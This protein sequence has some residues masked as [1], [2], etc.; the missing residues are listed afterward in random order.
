M[1]AIIGMVENWTKEQYQGSFEKRYRPPRKETDYSLNKSR[2]FVTNGGAGVG[3]GDSE[4]YVYNSNRLFSY[5]KDELLPFKPFRQNEKKILVTNV[6][7]YIHSLKGST[8][9]AAAAR[10]DND[11][12]D[13]DWE[14]VSQSLDNRTP[15]ECFI[16]YRSELDPKINKGRWTAEEEAKLLMLA[17]QFKEHDWD[18]IASL[19]DTH[20]TPFDCLRHYQQALNPKIMNTQEFSLEEDN[21]LKDA[22]ELYGAN[23]W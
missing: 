12:V 11:E 4:A 20:R 7:A 2:Y 15:I 5:Q 14:I 22:I 16:Q 23:C 8:A 10:E 1:E 3:G 6:E 21:L 17:K 13:I 9:T 18:T 19:L